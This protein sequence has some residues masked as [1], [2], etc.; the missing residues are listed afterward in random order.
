[1]MGLCLLCLSPLMIFEICFAA[2]F[3]VTVYSDSVDYEF[4]SEDYAVDFALLNLDSD[5]VKVNG[6]RIDDR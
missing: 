2:P 3:D 5:H 6:I 4:A 1:M